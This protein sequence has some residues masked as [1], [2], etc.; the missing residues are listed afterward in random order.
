MANVRHVD[1]GAGDVL[2]LVGTTKGAFF[3]RSRPQ[4]EQWEMGGPYFPGVTVYAMAFDGRGGRKRLLVGGRN[5]HF[6]PDLFHSDDFGRSWTGPAGPRV[7]YPAEANLA[8]E[9]M[10]QTAPGNATAKDTVYVGVEPAGLFVSTDAGETFELVQGLHDHPHRA[11]WTPGGGGLCMHTVLPH[12]VDPRKILVAVSTGG[13][14]RTEDG[15]ATW[16]VSNTGVRA[17]FNPDKYPELGQCVHK[18]A[19][20]ATAPDSLFL[21]NRGGLY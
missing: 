10:W 21:Q 15:G 8:V 19:R 20:D 14:Y 13:V 7:Q 6:A 4:R 16:H 18:V 17:D 9:K 2:V 1:V 5:E 12:P 3:F 11:K